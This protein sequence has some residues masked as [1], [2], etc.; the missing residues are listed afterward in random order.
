MERGG[1]Q[2]RLNLHQQI[3]GMNS[4]DGGVLVIDDTGDRKSGSETAHVGR[5]YLG[6]VGKLDQGIVAVSSLWA[7][8]RIYYPLHVKAYTPAEQLPL[9]KQDPAFHKKAEIDWPCKVV[10]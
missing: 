2:Q 10:K 5:Q 3:S 1:N 9:G 7:D 4:H 6:S 8:E